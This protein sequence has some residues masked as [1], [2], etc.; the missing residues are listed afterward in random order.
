MAKRQSRAFS[1]HIDPSIKL[2]SKAKASIAAAISGAAAAQIAD[3][4]LK[5]T[6]AFVPRI[7]WPGMYCID[8]SRFL[9]RGQ[10]EEMAQDIRG[11]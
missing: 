6:V 4:D 9:D 8:L 1:V 2:T 5:A 10:L 7:D 3:L 11:L